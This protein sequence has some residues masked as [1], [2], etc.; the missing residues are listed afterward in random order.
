MKDLVEYIVKNIVEQ[1]DEVEV[2]ETES[3]YGFIEIDIKV[4]SDDMGKVI[5]KQGKII[6]SIRKLAKA[7]AV[8]LGRRVQVNIVE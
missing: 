7:K 4:S 6:G 1:P 8:V 3:E 2:T 5:G